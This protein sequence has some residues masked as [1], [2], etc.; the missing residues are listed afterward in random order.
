MRLRAVLTVS[1][2]LLVAACGDDDT[3][4]V[5]G[6]AGE[7]PTSAAPAG[8]YAAELQALADARQQWADAAIDDYSYRYSQLCF[9]PQSEWI[10]TVV[11]GEVTAQEPAPGTEPIGGAEPEA[12]SMTEL[13]DLVEEE[14]AAGPAS[15]ELAFDPET[16]AL[17]RYW[18]DV[19]ERVADE[20]RGI[21]VLELV[22]AG[23]EPIGGPEIDLGSLTEHWG[24]GYGF[25]AGDP[26]QSTALRLS[27]NDPLPSGTISLPDPRIDAVVLVGADLYANW[28]DDVMEADEPRPVVERELDVVGGTLTV[29][30]PADPPICSGA[31]ARVVA[32]ALVLQLPDGTTEDLGDIEIVNDA[33]G[34]FAG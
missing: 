26:S 33:Y 19:D 16:G 22:E 13:F 27:A 32:Q 31:T 10:V 34:C 6:P 21:E 25:N 24:C 23:D 8:P 1:L 18:V 28:C 5:A 15:V 14:I 20:E 2:L 3:T 11:D 29:E 4:T 12:R 7:T 30:A 17:D 9:C